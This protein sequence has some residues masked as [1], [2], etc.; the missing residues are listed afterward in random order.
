MKNKGMGWH[1]DS[2]RH[3]KVGAIGGKAT[4]KK[5]GSEHFA[6]IGRM[7]GKKKKGYRKQKDEK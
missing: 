2:K 6:K 3:K 4:A 7:G 5:Y 1:G